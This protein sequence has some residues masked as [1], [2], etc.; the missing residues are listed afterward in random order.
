M[1]LFLYFR[2]HTQIPWLQFLVGTFIVRSA[3]L[4]HWYELVFLVTIMVFYMYILESFQ[5]FVVKAPYFNES[6][7]KSPQNYNSCWETRDIQYP[8]VSSRLATSLPLE[9]SSER[10]ELFTPRSRERSTSRPVPYLSDEG[11][12]WKSMFHPISR[13]LEVNLET[14]TRNLPLHKP[15][16]VWHI[17]FR[18]LNIGWNTLTRV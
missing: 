16:R 1:I 17:T 8:S 15:C 14:P 2:N 4:E 9:F 18:S 11:L 12:F 6:F 10:R 5:V 13:L 7:L 3:G